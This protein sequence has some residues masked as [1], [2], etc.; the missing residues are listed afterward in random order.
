M[1]GRQSGTPPPRRVD[2]TNRGTHVA[3]GSTVFCGAAAFIHVQEEG[4]E[5]RWLGLGFP[6]LRQLKNILGE[7]V[8]QSTGCVTSL[9]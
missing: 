3:S 9:G 5:G 4:R 1:E 6:P 8:K 2:E 7:T